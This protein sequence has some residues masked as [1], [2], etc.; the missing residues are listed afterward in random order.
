MSGLNPPGELFEDEDVTPE[1]HRRR[2][3]EVLDRGFLDHVED[4]PPEIL[5]ERLRDARS[6]EDAISYIRRNLHGRLDLLR[7]ELD[8]RKGGRGTDRRSGALAAALVDA[9][10]GGRGTHVGVGLRAA[11]VAGRRH[12]ERVLAEDHLARLPDLD[13]AEIE[14]IVGR[15]T[16]TERQLSDQ[17]RRLHEVI[18]GLEG[19][20]A[21]RYKSGLEPSLER[22]Q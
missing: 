14:E 2:I 22:L 21:R 17:R 12:A 1:E 18:D 13:V 16:T 20:L 8:H 15:L 7:A 19:E 4:L 6:E 9:G 10:S 11:A 3:D 5:R